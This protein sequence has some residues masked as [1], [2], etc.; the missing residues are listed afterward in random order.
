M[1][2]LPEDE[3]TLRAQISG[4]LSDGRLSELRRRAADLHAADLA[5]LLDWLEEPDDKLRLYALLD[6]D[7]A[8]DVIR[9]VGD[10]TRDTI[11]EHLSDARLAEVVERL[12]TDD[13]TDLVGELPEERKTTVLDRASAETRREVE[14]LLSYPHDTAGGIMKKEVAAVDTGSTVAEVIEQIRARADS[15]HDI[16]NVFVVD[17]RGHLVGLIPLRRLILADKGAPVEEVM[18]TDLVSV[19]VTVDQEEAAQ[20]FEKYDL[21]SL[22]VVDELGRLVGRITVDDIV[23]VISEEATEDILALGGLGSDATISASAL[24]ALRARIPWL[25]VNL[26]TATTAAATVALFESTIQALAIAAAFMNIV[27]SQGGA[28]GV[29]SMTLTVRGLALG[30]IEGKDAARVL[31]RELLTSVG[32][33]L[34]LGVVASSIAYLWTGNG[35]L[36]IVLGCALLMNLLIAATL[37]S[38][39]PITLKLLGVD[40]AVSSNVFVT[41]GTDIIGFFVFLS[42]LTAAL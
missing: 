4:L 18:T 16:H 19:P 33:G 9:D 40:P 34:V 27:T 1:P 24:R 7:V 23:D 29:Q 15:Y 30:E 32:N 14:D 42:L 26:I 37:G 6:A 39:V 20:Y 31:R 35:S 28:A 13:A 2:D 21:L 8:S 38:L 12:D 36:S 10:L 3:A 17:S 41:A 25:A 5:D 22:P 11:I